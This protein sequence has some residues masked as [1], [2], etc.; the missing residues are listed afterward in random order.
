MWLNFLTKFNCHWLNPHICGHPICKNNELKYNI[1]M[2]P[3]K[4]DFIW[5]SYTHVL[6][7]HVMHMWFAITKQPMKNF[8][9]V[10]Y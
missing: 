9:N 2:H 4:N 10:S 1:F 5:T 7:F 6:N 3:K 8:M